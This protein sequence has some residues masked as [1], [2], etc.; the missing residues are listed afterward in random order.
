VSNI[1]LLALIYAGIAF[2][3]FIF[4]YVSLTLSQQD[5]AYLFE[6]NDRPLNILI[7]ALYAIFWPISLFV[8]IL[9][10]VLD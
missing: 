4:F 8:F 2:I 6:K 10:K 1:L 5:Y 7:S 3:S 9:E